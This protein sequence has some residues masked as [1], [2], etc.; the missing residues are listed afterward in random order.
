MLHRTLL[1]TRYVH[2]GEGREGGGGV[3]KT[4]IDLNIFA[5]KKPVICLLAGNEVKICQFCGERGKVK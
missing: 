2:S 1:S 5:S 4:T 3:G